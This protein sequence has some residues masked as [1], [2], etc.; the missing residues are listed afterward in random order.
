MKNVSLL[1]NQF[2][3]SE[4]LKLYFI[5][6]WG[7]SMSFKGLHT[8][9]VFSS[10]DLHLHTVPIFS[11]LDLHLKVFIYANKFNSYEF[12]QSQTGGNSKFQCRLAPT[13]M[14]VS[15]TYTTP[16]AAHILPVTLR[17]KAIRLLQTSTASPPSNKFKFVL[18]CNFSY[19][20]F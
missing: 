2:I 20:S 15:I 18:N 17:Q 10:L 8:V 12:L 9:P 19:V 16:S 3:K 7:L 1:D 5:P 11:S 6:G 13:L 14:E 4:V